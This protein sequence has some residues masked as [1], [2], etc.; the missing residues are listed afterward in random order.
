MVGSARDTAPL[1]QPPPTSTRSSARAAR[2]SAAGK[3]TRP[4][5]PSPTPFARTVDASS[6]TSRTSPRRA[7]HVLGVPLRLAVAMRRRLSG[8]AVSTAPEPP[9]TRDPLR[10]EEDH[11]RAP[12]ADDVFDVDTALLGSL[13]GSLLSSFSSFS[14]FSSELLELLELLGSLLGSLL[15]ARE[16]LLR[17]GIMPRPVRGE[18]SGNAADVRV[19]RR[20]ARA[21]MV[22][23]RI[24][25]PSV[26]RNSST[27]LR[28]SVDS[29][30][31]R[32]LGRRASRQGSH[33]EKI[34][35][36]D[37]GTFGLDATD[38]SARTPHRVAHVDA[39]GVS[40]QD[41]TRRGVGV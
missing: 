18:T 38:H 7:R 11:L 15:R 3:T 19:T 23:Y 16:A 30:T 5:P 34:R 1:R 26:L 41:Q 36:S 6:R 39:G 8:A 14:S 21:R 33:G 20:P 10:L 2:I 13:L 12:V 9:S 22:D 27:S 24:P 40:D 31:R 35:G 25:S 32:R 29:T 37:S 4:S 17:R 28:V